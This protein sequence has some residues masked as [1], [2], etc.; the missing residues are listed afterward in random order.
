MFK[1]KEGEKSLFVVIQLLGTIVRYRSYFRRCTKYII[2]GTSL[3]VIYASAETHSWAYLRRLATESV[4]SVGLRCRKP[5]L[6][7]LRDLSLCP[8]IARNPGHSIPLQIRT[9]RELPLIQKCNHRDNRLTSRYITGTRTT[10]AH[11]TLIN[12]I[13]VRE[14]GSNSPSRM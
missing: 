14:K 4:V 13:S 2:K 5:C 7:C 9:T 11:D 6:V 10:P 3:N 8:S 1:P 12:P